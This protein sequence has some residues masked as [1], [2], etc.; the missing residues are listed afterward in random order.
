MSNPNSK[1]NSL[2]NSM[3][4]PARGMSNKSRMTN[5]AKN[6]ANSTRFISNTP[7]FDPSKTQLHKDELHFFYKDVKNLKGS[8]FFSCQY[9]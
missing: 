3:A 2:T 7:R 5:E 6:N 9:N 1:S 4:L 8:Y